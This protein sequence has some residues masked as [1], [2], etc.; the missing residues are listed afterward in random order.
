MSF[1]LDTFSYVG[2]RTSIHFSD[3]VLSGLPCGLFRASKEEGE[4]LIPELK[5][6]FDSFPLQ[7]SEDYEF[8]VKIHMLMPGQ[9]PC[10]PNW[11]CDNVAR[12]ANKALNY[13]GT[14]AT[15]QV[16]MLLWLSNGPCTEFLERSMTMPTVP[17][18]HGEVA[19]FINTLKG[20]IGDDVAV[21]RFVPPQ[22]WV[23]FSTAAPHRGR[24]SAQHQ[25]RVFVRATHRSILPVRPKV[26]ALRR[27][28]QVYLDAAQFTW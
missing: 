2:P 14:D 18:N 21:T 22:Q 10:V 5:P 19:D 20:S 6:L 3:E 13:A 24:A 17:T 8:D 4:H 7:N 15:R 26:H 11:H 9:Y 27:H 25:W 12:D 28:A 16:P 23:Q 1:R